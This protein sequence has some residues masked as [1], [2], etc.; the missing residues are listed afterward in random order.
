MAASSGNQL[1]PSELEL[2]LSIL[3]VGYNS[4]S[5]LT[6]CIGA[7]HSAVSS[8]SWEVLFVNNGT[9]VSEELITAKFPEVRVLASIGNVG[10]A[11]GN[12]YLAKHARGR[13]LLLLNPDTRLYPEA[14][15][16]L[17]D[18]AK[19]HP[20]FDVLG[21]ITMGQDG[22]P[23]AA[24]RL[25]LPS[26]A[27][28]L[29]VLLIGHPQPKKF[30]GGSKVLKVDALNGGFMM[31]R[32]DRW[33]A[34]GGL[35]EGFFL[36][37]EELDFFKRLKDAGG[38]AALVGESRIFHD[39]GSGDNFSANRIRFLTIG[40]AHYFHKNFRKPYAYACV[41]LIWAIALKRYLGASLLAS[42]SDWYA[43]MS[44][45]F[46][47]VAKSPTKWMWGYNSPGADPRKIR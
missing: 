2:D 11:A 38:Q 43:R 35:D 23:D 14:L 12:N 10:F 37:A 16:M 44:R 7:V 34:L 20:Q 24:A 42:R 47:P 31:A 21:G 41:M 27:S 45:G 30:A 28:L 17:L 26:F 46:G 29:R 1:T 6:E 36:Y 25:Q 5:Y 9:D 8:Y 40:N 32:R 4:A 39:F 13:W 33:Q 22:E 19:E 3:V 15:D 18:T